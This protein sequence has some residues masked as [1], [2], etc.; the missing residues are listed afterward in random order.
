MAAAIAGE[1]RALAFKGLAEDTAVPPPNR[2]FY[3]SQGASRMRE[4]VRSNSARNAVP[5]LA[6]LRLYCS[7]A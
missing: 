2:D 1:S 4:L 6:C 5:R 3:N 7:T